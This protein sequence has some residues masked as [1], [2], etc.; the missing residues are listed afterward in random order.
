MLYILK[1]LYYE[2]LLDPE[3]VGNREIRIGKKQQICYLK[4]SK[5]SFIVYME[6]RFI[7]S[8]SGKIIFDDLFKFENNN[9]KTDFVV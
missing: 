1:H 3:L 4:R 6:T 8:E 9:Y 2:N 7:I 5:Q